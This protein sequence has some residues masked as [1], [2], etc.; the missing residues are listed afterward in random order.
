MWL[1]P[2]KM[3]WFNRKY[4]TQAGRPFYVKFQKHFRDF[5]YGNGKPKF[6]QYLLDNK[7]SIGSMEDITEFLHTTGKRRMMNTL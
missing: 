2:G 6:A 3:S 1:L 4:S 7:H 5:K